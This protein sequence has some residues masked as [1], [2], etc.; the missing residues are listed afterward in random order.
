MDDK[1]QQLVGHSLRFLVPARS[2]RFLQ[3][4]LSHG[5]PGILASYALIGAVIALGA[6]GFIVDRLADTAPWFVVVGLLAGVAIGFYNLV[7]TV[8]RR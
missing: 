2:I 5:E 3:A 7:K 8:G 1:N 6:L 4:N